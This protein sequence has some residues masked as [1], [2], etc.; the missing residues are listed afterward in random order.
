MQEAAS[1]QSA[2]YQQKFDTGEHNGNGERPWCA[3]WWQN[4][5]S[6]FHLKCIGCLSPSVCSTS[7][8]LAFLIFK[9]EW[10]CITFLEV[11]PCICIWWKAWFHLCHLLLTSIL[12]LC[13]NI[14][15]RFK[16]LHAVL[17]VDSLPRIAYTLHANARCLQNT[18]STGSWAGALWCFPQHPCWSCSKPVGA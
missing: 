8:A 17:L 1:F 4:Y 7:H 2:S 16:H 10:R 3:F 12:S 6:I 13:R 9:E 14:K 15:D 18:S 11:F 5:W